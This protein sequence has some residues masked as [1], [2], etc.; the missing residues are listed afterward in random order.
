MPLFG[1]GK[2]PGKE[3]KSVEKSMRGYVVLAKRA[4]MKLKTEGR[5][6]GEAAKKAELAGLR[7]SNLG[8]REQ[9]EYWE[10][11]TAYDEEWERSGPEKRA[12][13]EW[14][15]H[16]WGRYM[17]DG[18]SPKEADERARELDYKFWAGMKP[19]S[20]K[21]IAEAGTLEHVSSHPEMYDWTGMEAGRAYIAKVQEANTQTLNL[22]K[23][24]GVAL[25][26]V[27]E[28]WIIHGV[29]KGKVIPEMSRKPK[30]MLESISW[31]LPYEPD[32]AVS[33]G[34][35]VEEAYNRVA[36]EQTLRYL[37]EELSRK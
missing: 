7:F 20:E 22:L 32:I 30:N 15:M 12:E 9:R 37:Y 1:K 16:H 21:P 17:G 33:V 27:I 11:S 36:D 24:A 2:K 6:D 35:V 29:L 14:R 28:D 23:E 13:L 5:I 8:N 26:H 10:I 4:A 19:E 25:E 18:F 34:G 31:A 3:D